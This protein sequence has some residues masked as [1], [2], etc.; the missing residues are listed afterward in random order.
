ML[1]PRCRAS[2]RSCHSSQPFMAEAELEYSNEEPN[3]GAIV[4]HSD[5]QHSDVARRNPPDERNSSNRLEVAT[6]T[7]QFFPGAQRF[8]ITAGSLNN[9]QNVNHFT[10]YTWI[11][12]APPHTTPMDH[13]ATRLHDSPQGFER[14]QALRPIDNRESSHRQED[15]SEGA[16]VQVTSTPRREQQSQTVNRPSGQDTVPLLPQQ[17]ATAIP[18]MSGHPLQTGASPTANVLPSP[19]PSPQARWW[20][21]PSGLS[22][23]NLYVILMLMRRKGYP[24]WCPS[25]NLAQQIPIAH[26]KNGISLGDVG[27]ITPDGGFDF[28]FNVFADRN[29]P[30]NGEGKNVPDGFTPCSWS[31]ATRKTRM[32]PGSTIS[33]RSIHVEVASLPMLRPSP[34]HFRV[35]NS[36]GA[37][38]ALPSGADTS[39]ML[40]PDE[41]KSYIEANAMAWYKYISEARRIKLH[42]GDLYVVTGTTKAENWGLFAIDDVPGAPGTELVFQPFDAHPRTYC[43]TG[44][45]HGVVKASAADD[46]TDE[47]NQTLFITGFRLSL[48]RKWFDYYGRPDGVRLSRV[49]HAT[50]AMQVSQW[51]PFSARGHGGDGSGGGR[52][53]IRPPIRQSAELPSHNDQVASS[54]N[55]MVLERS[56]HND[57]APTQSDVEL[58]YQADKYETK[59]LTPAQMFHPANNIHEYIRTMLPSC[60]VVIT[61]DSQWMSMLS[62][63]DDNFPDSNELLTCMLHNYQPLLYAGSSMYHLC[64]WLNTSSTPSGIA[65]LKLKT[66]GG[67]GNLQKEEKISSSPES[68]Y[69][70]PPPSRKTTLDK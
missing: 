63:T 14:P 18:R 66:N 4:Q 46:F 56:N 9:A 65:G 3:H 38:C 28:L 34:F 55:T 24:M 22:D 39:E 35:R 61:H 11:S 15:F 64:E 13:P 59:S 68:A 48:G 19:P 40:N 45:G 1:E 53:I 57:N 29:D 41:M 67:S 10:N 2:E 62:D 31:R 37:V 16:P 17:N 49:E 6:S 30:L 58:S 44:C 23:A 54:S 52:A 42:N 7:P 27:L 60:D 12:P 51:V 33:T 50:Q 70:T 36:P 43:W 32:P 25:P 26:R 69:R 5:G 20:F 8:G 47:T 21:S